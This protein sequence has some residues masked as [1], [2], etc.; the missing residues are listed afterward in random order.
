VAQKDATVADGAEMSRVLNLAA[1]VGP[2]TKQ[3]LAGMSRNGALRSRH[4]LIFIGPP[5]KANLKVVFVG[6]LGTNT[7]AII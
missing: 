4:P 5:L 7:L 6:I 2:S 3:Q 1:R